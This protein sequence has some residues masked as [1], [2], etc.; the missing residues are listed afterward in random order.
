MRDPVWT[1]WI[2][3]VDSVIAPAQPRGAAGPSTE[4]DAIGGASGDAGAGAAWAVR[5]LSDLA[6]PSSLGEPS[7]PRP[8]RQPGEAGRR[9][10]T[11]I[12]AGGLLE[13]ASDLRI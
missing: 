11:E 3:G 7:L 2:G 8:R 10:R 1:T 13:P 4:I 6:G 12:A 9:R 5:E